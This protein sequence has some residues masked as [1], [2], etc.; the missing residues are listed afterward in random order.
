MWNV[1]KLANSSVFHRLPFNCCASIAPFYASV[2]RWKLIIDITCYLFVVA[3]NL[4]IVKVRRCEDFKFIH[5]AQSAKTVCKQL[6]VDYEPNV[7]DGLKSE[8]EM[9]KKMMM[10]TAN[11]LF[12][13]LMQFW[14]TP[15]TNFIICAP[16]S[17]LHGKWEWDFGIICNVWEVFMVGRVYRYF[18]SE[19]SIYGKFSIKPS[20]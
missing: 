6:R 12:K 1:I 14:Q 4:H 18:M 19:F 15:Q 16:Q 20:V 9:S 17:H 7:T 3:T 13:Y 8:Q 11:T 10:K 5:T 2:A